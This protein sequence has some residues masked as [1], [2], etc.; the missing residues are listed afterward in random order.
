[1]ACPGCYPTSI[2]LP[3]IPLLRE[4]LIKPGSIIADSLSGVSGA[5]R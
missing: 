1:V 2:L 4:K 5:G 3:V